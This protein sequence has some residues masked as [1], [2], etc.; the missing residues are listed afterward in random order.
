MCERITFLSAPSDFNQV[1]MVVTV[2]WV[3]H[4]VCCSVFYFSSEDSCF[5]TLRWFLLY[6]MSSCRSS[7]MP[8]LGAPSH[9]HLTASPATA[10]RWAPRAEPLPA[11]RRAHVLRRVSHVLLR[12][13]G[14]LS[15]R[16]ALSPA[17]C[18]WVH[19]LHLR[20]CAWPANRFLR[21]VFLD[22]VCMR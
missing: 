22:P 19:P 9:A 7:H 16:P 12:A 14:S 20:L 11:G 3:V 13:S 18:P 17:L 8:S 2:W 21:P 6:N 15:V 5:T 4:W 1:Q 10:P